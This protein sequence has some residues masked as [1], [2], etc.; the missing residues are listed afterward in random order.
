[1]SNLEQSLIDELK[2]EDDIAF[3]ASDEDLVKRAVTSANV[4]QGSK[5]LIML[6]M[7]SIWVVFA[8]IFM[9]ILQPVFKNMAKNSE[10]K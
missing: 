9:K 3:K 1:M 5:D 4:N 8:S 10:R 7:A 2:R 6:G